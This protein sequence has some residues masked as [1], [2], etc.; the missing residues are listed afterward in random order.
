M[1][2]L[3]LSAAAL[4]A[5]LVAA[6]AVLAFSQLPELFVWAAFVGWASYDHSGGPAQAAIRSST[7]LVSGVTMAWLVAIV[8]AA[9]LLPLNTPAATATAAGAASFLIVI[10]SRA[11]PL[12]VVPATFYGFAST[13]AY[14]SL[15][16]GAFPSRGPKSA[17]F[18]SASSKNSV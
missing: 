10:V 17:R 4:A 13:F 18:L 11:A 8:V 15:S 3:S 5:A 2:L 14:L 1:H 12:S 6:V 9:R 16:G 7:A